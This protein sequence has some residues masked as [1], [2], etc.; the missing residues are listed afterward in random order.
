VFVPHRR[1]LL[2]FLA[3][4]AVIGGAGMID[5]Q[6]RFH[7]ADKAEAMNCLIGFGGFLND[8]PVFSF[9]HLFKAMAFQA[10]A[11]V[12][13]YLSLFKPRQRLQICL[14]D[15]N[16]CGKPNTCASA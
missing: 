7:L 8:R 12:G 1:Q 3:S 9:G 5:H 16:M 13:E 11:S 6:G 2:P 4:R 10:W 15:S 14:G